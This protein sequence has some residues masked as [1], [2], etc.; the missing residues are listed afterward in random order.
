MVAAMAPGSVVVDLA[1][2][3]G[4]NVEGLVSRAPTVQ[5]GGALV[6]GGADVPSQMPVH[7]SQLYS[8][9]VVA[10]LDA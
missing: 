1:A 7:A 6:W 9:N 8:A 3:T 5:I 4:G 10:V 2:E